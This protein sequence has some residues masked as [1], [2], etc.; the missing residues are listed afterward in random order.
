MW[1]C[2]FRFQGYRAWY[3][4]VFGGFEAKEQT[5]KI[6]TQNQFPEK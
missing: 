1:Y 4:R 5:H 3:L 6:E 2:I